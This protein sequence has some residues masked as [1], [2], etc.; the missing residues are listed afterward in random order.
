MSIASDLALAALSPRRLANI[1]ARPSPAG[2]KDVPNGPKHC[3]PKPQLNSLPLLGSK[4]LYFPTLLLA[5]DNTTAWQDLKRLLEQDYN[6]IVASDPETALAIVLQEPPNL[7]LT[8]M[9]GSLA[10]GSH[11]IE[12]LRGN[13]RTATLPIVVLTPHAAKHAHR[14]GFGSEQFVFEAGNPGAVLTQVEMQLRVARLHKATAGRWPRQEVEKWRRNLSSPSRTCAPRKREIEVILDHTPFLL[15][16]CTRDLR[17][18]YVSR[19][20]PGCWT[21]T[22][23]DCRQAHCR[24]YGSGGL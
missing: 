22:G 5:L 8:D 16:H 6:V 11:L 21:A 10:D 15:T 23:G 12:Q 17:Y 19:G 4:F 13:A 3:I 24:D 2:T 18:H 1:F 9:L 7:V 14:L 20:M